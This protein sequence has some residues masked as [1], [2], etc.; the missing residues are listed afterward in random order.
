MHISCKHCTYLHIREVGKSLFGYIIFEPKERNYW[1]NC[2]TIATT[3]IT[4]QIKG[5][6]FNWAKCTAQIEQNLL[7]Y[8]GLN[9]QFGFQDTLFSLY[10]FYNK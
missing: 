4:G 7:R 8:N 10:F 5:V 2:S 1:L 6:G 9:A 3:E